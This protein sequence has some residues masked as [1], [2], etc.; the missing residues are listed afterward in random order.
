M[1]PVTIAM[2]SSARAAATS[3]FRQP[4]SPQGFPVVYSF[5]AALHVA[6]M[7]GNRSSLVASAYSTVLTCRQQATDHGLNHKLISGRP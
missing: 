1:A 4:A 6:S 3:R 5:H 7:I 2:P